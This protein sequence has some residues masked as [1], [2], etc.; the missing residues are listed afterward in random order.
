[1][2]IAEESNLRFDFGDHEYAFHDQR[3]DGNT[4]WKG[5][6]FR[7]KLEVG[8][9]W[10]EVKNYNRTDEQEAQRASNSYQKVTEKG[11]LMIFTEKFLGTTAF[12]AWSEKFNAEPLHYVVLLE[13]PL[14]AD[15][16]ILSTATQELKSNIQPM[17]GKRVK[18]AVVN[19]AGWNQFYPEFPAKL[20]N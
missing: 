16:A 7:I 6:D 3:G 12:L 2:A 8:W 10:L 17:A 15:A 11:G 14:N 13:P 1:M 5:V 19:L 18:V 9:L 20:I 4:N